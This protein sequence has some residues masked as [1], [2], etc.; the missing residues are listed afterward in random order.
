METP[1]DGKRVDGGE[2]GGGGILAKSP[3][4][5]DT[6]SSLPQTPAL[7]ICRA[8]RR[9]HDTSRTTRHARQRQR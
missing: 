6:L 8:R 2:G 5:Q 9:T 4:P 1:H 3:L 7:L